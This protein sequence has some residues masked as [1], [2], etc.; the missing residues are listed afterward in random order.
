L[1]ADVALVPDRL[2][3]ELVVEQVEHF[4]LVGRIDVH[5]D[6][7]PD[8]L[9]LR[10][11]A[12]REPRGTERRQGGRRHGSENA[13]AIHRLRPPDEARR[14]GRFS[15]CRF[16]SFVSMS[17]ATPT[18]SS[19]SGSVP[20]LVNRLVSSSLTGMAFQRAIGAVSPAI[21]TVPLPAST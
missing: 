17:R 11:G 5:L 16:A 14:Y 12:R 18:T 9:R 2:G 19:S 13:S 3:H 21:V 6:V 8:V 1:H 20:V 15:S 10:P 7:E 4:L